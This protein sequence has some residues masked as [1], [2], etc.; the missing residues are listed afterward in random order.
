VEIRRLGTSG[1]R[2]SADRN[3][4]T[5][6]HFWQRGRELGGHCRLQIAYYLSAKHQAQR[7]VTNAA[8][9]RQ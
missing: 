3:A 8:K 2:V 5:E 4:T 7:T 9:R 1:L 6:A